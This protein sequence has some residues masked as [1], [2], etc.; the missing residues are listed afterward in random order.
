[1]KNKWTSALISGLLLFCI[2]EK[3]WTQELASEQ[4]IQNIDF[5]NFLN[6]IGTQ[7]LGYL[8]EKFN[9]DIADAEVAAAKMFPD[10]ELS[11][12]WVDNGQRR[13]EMG[14]GFEAELSWN[15]ELGGKRKARKN[16]ANSQRVLAALAL[17]DYFQDLRAEATIAFLKTLQHQMIVDVKK[18][19]YE[20]MKQISKSDSIR[21]S[22]GQI[23]KVA[24]IQSRLET[25]SM[26]N[27]VAEAENEWINSLL[28]LKKLFVVHK[29]D[30]LFIPQGNFDKFDRLFDYDVLV[31]TAHTH[32][33]NYLM[34]VQNQTVSGHEV[35][36][37]QAE[38]VL[39]LG[40]S[41][42]MESN[43][44]V[45][46]AVAPTPGN[47]AVKAGISIPLKFS[48]SKD[49]ALK[50]ALYNQKKNELEYRDVALELEKEIAQA[51]RTYLT[52]QKQIREFENSMLDEARE[53]LDGITYS[54]QRGASSLLEVLDA[55]RT[56]NETQEA[57]IEARFDYAVAL[58]ELEKAVG[59]WDIEF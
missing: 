41:I 6:Q 39:D 20:S 17:Q 44:F 13:M 36:L 14:Y 22:L 27:E 5:P 21:F 28:D 47:T 35:R 49:A 19:S 23:T 37:A 33:S 16:V 38:R 58:V 3:G 43:S 15:L 10:P 26:K 50:T 56:Y 31:E 25:N 11:F 24:S 7:N 53:V 57:Y 40:L 32:Q 48:N 55:Q 18:N 29:T 30:S 59:I 46:N 45:R 54:Y 1:M 8:A 34:A 12:G 4:P 52:K 9:L 51:L 42:G 2:A